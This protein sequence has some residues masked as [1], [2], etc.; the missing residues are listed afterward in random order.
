MQGG[1]GDTDKKNRILDTIGEREGGVIWENSIET[2]STIY[3]R[4]SQWE[5]DVW[6]PGG[7]GK[8]MGGGFKREG[9]HVC[10]WPIHID[11]WKKL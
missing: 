11:V 6:P 5:F 3:K 8:E 10:L 7:G 1:K 9:T 2:Y 4:D